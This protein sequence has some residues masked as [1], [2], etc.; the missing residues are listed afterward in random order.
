[1]KV[2]FL[3]TWFPYPPSNGAKI[4][5]YYLLKA[6]S[7]EHQ[8]ALL[9]FAD[10]KLDPCFVA[11]MAG[12]CEE[13]EVVQ[14]DP[15]A[16]NR[17]L[18]VLGWFSTMPSALAATHSKEM[19]ARVSRLV[20]D[21]TPDCVIAST[22]L[23]ARYVRD[24]S[25]PYKVVDL[26][27]ISTSVQ[28]E[29]YAS[30][31]TRVS[32][33][34]RRLA[35]LKSRAYESRLIAGFD[36]CLVVSDRDRQALE[37]IRTGLR[38]RIS[39]IPNGVDA[40]SGLPARVSRSPGTLI[41][42]GALTYEP[43]F[44]AMEY[45]LRAIFP[46]IR[47]QAPEATLRITGETAGVP[48]NRLPLD[49]HVEFT[50]HLSDVRPAI[51]GS[52]VCVVPLLSGGGSRVKVIEAM[53][54]GTPVV[55]TPKGA[56]GLEVVDGEHLLVARSPAEFAEQAVR[57][58]R[59]PELRTTLATKAQRLVGEKYDWKAIGTDLCRVLESH[60]RRARSDR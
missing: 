1:V 45:F 53:A 20:R 57:L 17:A 58:L 28:W 43:N 12:M 18:R 46:L 30:S 13:V 48:I 19:A 33:L 42:S 34:R 26:E 31:R 44:K 14:R 6:L 4:R 2:L 15:F 36:H 24:A 52:C 55:S 40:S 41:Y 16:R 9:S 8:V 27:N 11:H 50:G 56:E 25:L 39:V 49:G 59:D 60:A 51:S 3:A 37:S 29:Q 10:R 7:S 35:W 47:R 21:F 5:T 54:L 23:T 38:P 32:R 22:A